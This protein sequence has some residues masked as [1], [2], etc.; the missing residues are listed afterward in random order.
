[1]KILRLSLF[2]LKKNKKEAIVVAFLTLITTML[3]AMVVINSSKISKTF[4]D[5]LREIGAENGILVIKKD[6]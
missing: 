4:D 3:L 5:S 2:N 6:V 1:M